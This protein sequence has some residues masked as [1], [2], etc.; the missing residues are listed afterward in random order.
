M[1]REYTNIGDDV[2]ILRINQSERA[3]SNKRAKVNNSRLASC[4][5]Q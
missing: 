3:V 2:K 5:K 1:E 4:A